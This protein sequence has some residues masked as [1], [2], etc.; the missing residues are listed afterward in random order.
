MQCPYLTYGYTIS[1]SDVLVV[2][3]IYQ[4]SH[5]EEANYGE[6]IVTNKCM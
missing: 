2:T 4:G 6:L 5:R 3:C 1:R